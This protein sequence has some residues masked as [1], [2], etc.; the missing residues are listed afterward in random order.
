MTG[1]QYRQE[2]V[3]AVMSFQKMKS[4]G[5]VGL[6]WIGIFISLMAIWGVATFEITPLYTF[7]SS[8][9]EFADTECPTKGCDFNCVQR[10]FELYKEWKHDNSIVLYRTRKQPW[11]SPWEWEEL[12]THPRWRLSY[13]PMS[14]NLKPRESNE[15]ERWMWARITQTNQQIR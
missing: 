10:R 1:L 13:L 12:L 11:W 15:F 2:G 3:F 7:E 4:F 9:G 6:A 14:K 8:D 5:V